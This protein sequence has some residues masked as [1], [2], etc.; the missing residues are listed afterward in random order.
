MAYTV[1][2]TLDADT[3]DASPSDVTLATLATDLGAS[4]IDINA[5]LAALPTE[6]P[7]ADGQFYLNSG[8]VTISAG[9]A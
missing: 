3:G 1:R 2:I 5:L 7:L 6:D 8:V 4:G 9:D